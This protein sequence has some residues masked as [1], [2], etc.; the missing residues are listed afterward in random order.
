EFTPNPHAHVM[1]TMREIHEEGFGKKVREWNDR[2]LLGGWREQ[3]EK[4]ANRE[5]E[6]AG[7]GVRIDHRR[8]EEQ[9][10]EAL[11]K[12]QYE[13]AIELDRAP[14]HHKGVV[15]TNMHREGL[16]TERLERMQKAR[17]KEL[18]PYLKERK[19]LT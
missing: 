5:L 13:R 7:H 4:A 17:P 9:K 1:L 14:T 15:A 16:E 11:S 8:L 18:A 10:E 19:E 3:W 6:N 2:A 12:G